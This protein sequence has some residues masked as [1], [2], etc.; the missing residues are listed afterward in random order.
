MRIENCAPVLYLGRPRNLMLILLN[1]VKRYDWL[2]M[3]AVLLLLILGLLSL[4]S[5]SEVSS[6][7]FFQKQLLWAVLGLVCLVIASF[8]DFRLF[9]TQSFVVL[10]FYLVAVALL[11]VVLAGSFTLR[12]IQFGGFFL[13]PVEPTKLS[14]IIL[15]A[16]FFSKRH[17]EIYRIGH[18]LISGAY[19][20][21]PALLVFLQPNLGSALVLVAIWL[22]IVAFSGM[23]LKHLVIFFLL[24]S[25]VSLG[26]WNFALAPYQKSRITSFINPYADP[27]GAGY[28]VIQ[29]MIAV[30]S[31]R[32]WGKGLGYGSQSHLNFLPE[33]ETDFIF[34]AFAE[35][36]GFVGVAAMLVLISMVLWRILR[37]GQLASD[38][39][40]RLYAMGFAAL[41][42][43]QSF[44]HI[45]MNMG[46]LPITGLTL[47]F[48]SYGGSSLVTLLMGVGILQNIKMNSRREI[49]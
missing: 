31:G 2:L 33:A 15:L 45:G 23:R 46:I 22:A 34:A 47:P 27:K 24:S 21:L 10:F 9:K 3:G 11:A 35:E 32:I 30:G 6:S 49:E 43:V 37:I 26:A 36:W 7:K 16:K 20:F 14:L 44:I 8:I 17:I 39:F 28:Q 4:F 41:I 40:S 13:Q 1:H 12:W 19:F 25:V 5:L 29:S 18:L 42:F 48:V 38:N